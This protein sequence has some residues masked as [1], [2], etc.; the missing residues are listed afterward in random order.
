M[1]AGQ[2]SVMIGSGKW[3]PDS[4]PVAGTCF[5]PSPVT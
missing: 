5:W 1:E 4:T 2:V 3:N